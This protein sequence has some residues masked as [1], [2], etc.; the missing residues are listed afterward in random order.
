MVQI[1]RA[2]E[3]GGLALADGRG[4][5]Q[6]EDRGEASESALWKKE[7]SRNAV[8]FVRRI[9]KLSLVKPAPA[10]RSLI[11]TSKGGSFVRSG[12]GPIAASIPSS[13]CRRRMDQ[14]LGVLTGC[15]R[16]CDI[17]VGQKPR[18][19]CS[20]RRRRLVRDSGFR[21][22]Q[23]RQQDDHAAEIFDD[24]HFF[25]IHSNA[26]QGSIFSDILYV[27]ARVTRHWPLNNSSRRFLV[28]CNLL[29][30]AG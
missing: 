22:G 24:S 14:S 23:Y 3:A 2:A 20:G 4:L 12:S 1:R 8:A 13:I 10:Y 28:G 21:G 27:L 15:S 17:A 29:D 6:G 26:A 18:A 9:G 7:I 30:R 11:C 16:P 25:V 19:D 5:V